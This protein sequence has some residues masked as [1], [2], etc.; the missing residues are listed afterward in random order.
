MTTKAK[1]AKPK[2]RKTHPPK[3]KAR[4]AA[5]ASKAPAPAAN[6]APLAPKQTQ[7]IELLRRPGGTSIAEATEVLGWQAHSVRGAI[8]GVIKKKLGLVV[9]VSKSEDATRRYHVA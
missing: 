3:S 9:T 7:L 4:L 5:A 8:S 1:S 2:S 6:A